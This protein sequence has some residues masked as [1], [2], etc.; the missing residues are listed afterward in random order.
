MCVQNS[1]NEASTQNGQPRGHFEFLA[2]PS[3]IYLQGWWGRIL[4]PASCVTK[5]NG[6]S[7]PFRVES[8][9]KLAKM[10][11]WKL[12]WGKL[13]FIFTGA[14]PIQ[15]GSWDAFLLKVWSWQG[16]AGPSFL[17]SL[18]SRLGRWDSLVFS[19]PPFIRTCLLPRQGERLGWCSPLTL[20]LL[21]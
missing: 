9:L 19:F 10:Q 20:F 7:F 2:G 21:T 6:S 8:H 12:H 13:L 3:G 16:Y 1:V 15:D 5:K 11:F 17:F 18:L 14:R 4:D